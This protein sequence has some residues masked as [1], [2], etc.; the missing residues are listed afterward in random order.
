MSTLEA[1]PHLP[2][3]K[4]LLRPKITIQ[5]PDASTSMPVMSPQTATSIYKG[6]PRYYTKAPPTPGSH[7]SD[8]HGNLYYNP[9]NQMYHNKASEFMFK[10]FEGFKDFTMN[11]AKSGLSAG[12]KSAFWFY[13]KLKLWS[14][15]WFTHLFLTLCLVVYSLIG[16]GIFA[17]LEGKL[18][19]RKQFQLKKSN[20]LC[21]IIDVV[22]NQDHFK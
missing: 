1:A 10:Q 4:R 8:P 15:K 13:N 19:N 14:K 7:I 17:A 16:A 18:V 9:F 20:V 21:M 12:E 5:I 6:T 2:S 22:L 3:S 11:T